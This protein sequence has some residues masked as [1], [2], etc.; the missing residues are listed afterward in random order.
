MDVDPASIADNQRAHLGV[1]RICEI[2][3]D[4][5]ADMLAHRFDALAHREL[6]MADRHNWRRRSGL[7]IVGEHGGRDTVAQEPSAIVELS[8][9]TIV[10]RKP[11]A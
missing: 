4:K 11:D 1:L 2:C 3:V 9:V 10:A 7:R 8:L 6:A 5:G